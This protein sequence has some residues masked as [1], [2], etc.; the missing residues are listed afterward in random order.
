MVARGAYGMAVDHTLAE[1]RE[2]ERRIPSDDVE[3]GVCACVG[4]I[5]RVGVYV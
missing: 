3:L 2:R 5:G 4:K 1:M